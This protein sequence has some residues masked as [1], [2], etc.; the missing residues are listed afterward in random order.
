MLGAPAKRFA[1]RPGR[2]VPPCVPPR[3]LC[4]LTLCLANTIYKMAGGLIHEQP[5]E[6]QLSSQGQHLR[7]L[8]DFQA[9]L[10]ARHF[11]SMS[12][13]RCKQRSSLPPFIFDQLKIVF[14]RLFERLC[15]ST[16]SKVG[17]FEE[18][19]EL[20]T[21]DTCKSPKLS[22]LS[23]RQLAS[24]RLRRN[25]AMFHSVSMFFREAVGPC[26]CTTGA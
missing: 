15:C 22:G 5:H 21:W 18:Q 9:N 11:K 1:G 7:V 10:W 25:G 4:A 20:D 3:H 12:W 14:E 24:Q 19:E 6:A 23:M 26:L 13:S 17:S 16:C 2:F 8:G